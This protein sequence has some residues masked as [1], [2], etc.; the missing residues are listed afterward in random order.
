MSDNAGGGRAG[1][2][3]QREGKGGF[4]SG[5]RHARG[6]A[7]TRA[8]AAPSLSP[9]SLSFTHEPS[10]RNTASER[11]VEALQYARVSK[12][13]QYKEVSKETVWSSVKREQERKRKR[14]STI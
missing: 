3:V 7:H 14:P 12:E 10:S 2:G 1:G 6:R 9:P 11:V 4:G 5:S 13:T 8:P